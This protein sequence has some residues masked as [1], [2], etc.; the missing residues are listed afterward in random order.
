MNKSELSRQ[1]QVRNRM[2]SPYLKEG[3]L[4]DVIAAITVLGTYPFYKLAVNRWAARIS[5][6]EQRAEH[7][8][9][10]LEE[11]PEFFRQTSDGQKFSLVWRR[12]FR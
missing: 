5:G 11:H 8:R 9:R 2:K 4:G 7:W 10:V 3:R 12:Q 6:S 1:Q